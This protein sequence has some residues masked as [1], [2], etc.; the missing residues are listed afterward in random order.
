MG[1]G[2]KVRE[3]VGEKALE[4]LE[5][6]IKDIDL[7]DQLAEMLK[8]VVPLKVEF[9]V[10]GN[11]KLEVNVHGVKNGKLWVSVQRIRKEKPEKPEIAQTEEPADRPLEELEDVEKPEAEA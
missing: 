9:T 7:F 5:D 8:T 11:K 3:K 10:K 6:M 1:I 2:D 4:M